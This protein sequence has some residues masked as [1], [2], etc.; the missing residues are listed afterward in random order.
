MR[1]CGG[2][3]GRTAEAVE[4]V[5]ERKGK[6]MR[7][8]SLFSGIGGFDLGFERA[9]MECA[10]QV[11]FDEQASAVLARHW[12]DV[13]RFK[14]VRGV[15]KHNLPTVE[16]ICG[17]F[18]CQDISRANSRRSGLDGK[19]SGLWF[20]FAR[21]IDDLEPRWIVVENVEG[22]LSSNNGRDFGYILWHLA[23][24]GYDAEWEVLPAAA[25]GAPH[26]RERV[27]IVAYTSGLRQ[28]P[29][30]VFTGEDFKGFAQTPLAW[31]G[32]RYTDCPD[33]CVRQT[34]DFEFLRMDDGISDRLDRGR[35]QYAGNAIVPAV[36]EWIGRRI[37]ALE[38]KAR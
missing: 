6:L 3:G 25:F 26:R 17:G 14:D 15:G 20:E 27:F 11:E 32:S 31:W 12:P 21:L 7:F 2:R 35:Y 19:R 37:M 23:A 38:G 34:P 9:G 10:A 16:L 36:A 4:F 8:I 13:P 30:E 29:F 5:S 1:D 33:G 22:L 24:R 18:P 28:S